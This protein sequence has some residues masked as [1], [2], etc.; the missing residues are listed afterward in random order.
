L[1]NT[2]IRMILYQEFYQNASA[3]SKIKR[4]FIK[5]LALSPHF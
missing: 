2:R 1:Y 3:T 4:N 5:R